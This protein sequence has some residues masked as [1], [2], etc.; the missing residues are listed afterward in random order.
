ML[1]L[2]LDVHAR[3]LAATLNVIDEEL[4]AAALAGPLG[5]TLTALVAEAR[6]E[7]LEIA[8]ATLPAAWEGGVEAPARSAGRPRLT[9]RSE[10]GTNV[11]RLV[12]A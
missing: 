6:A 1:S 5:A 4:R 3:C 10:P 11:V 12:P 2:P 9:G 7:A 8:H